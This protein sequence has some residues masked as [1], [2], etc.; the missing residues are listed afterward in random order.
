MGSDVRYIVTD[1]KEE[2]WPGKVPA[3]NSTKNRDVNEPDLHDHVSNSSL[4]M[5][6]PQPSVQTVQTSG[7]EA[8]VS[9]FVR[10]ANWNLFLSFSVLL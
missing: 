7:V 8:F 3:L 10:D 5:V 1:K 9:I 2:E 6:Q 4:T